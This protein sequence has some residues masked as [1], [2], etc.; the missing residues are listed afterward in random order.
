M[1]TPWGCSWFISSCAKHHGDYRLSSVHSSSLPAQC[2]LDCST[3]RVLYA[4]LLHC[5]CYRTARERRRA[6]SHVK[7]VLNEFHALLSATNEK[8]TFVKTI[9]SNVKLTEHLSNAGA[10]RSVNVRTELNSSCTAAISLIQLS[11]RVYLLLMHAGLLSS[12]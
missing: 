8:R 3:S 4:P 1:H 6:G 9:T 11:Y 2:C 7:K 10:V 5:L 12:Q